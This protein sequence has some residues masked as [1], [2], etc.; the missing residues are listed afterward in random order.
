MS[1]HFKKVESSSKEA[2]AVAQGEP[3]T[4]TEDCLRQAI[5]NSH[6]YGLGA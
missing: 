6:L 3:N 5:K 1:L 2:A 4:H